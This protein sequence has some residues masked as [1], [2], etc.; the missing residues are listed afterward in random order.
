MKTYPT[1]SVCRHYESNVRVHFS[2]HR[3]SSGGLCSAHFTNVNQEFCDELFRLIDGPFPVS[4][5]S[6]FLRE[7]DTADKME[8]NFRYCLASAVSAVQRYI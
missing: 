7:A 8:K 2:A 3:C 5:V 4:R 1:D 6:A